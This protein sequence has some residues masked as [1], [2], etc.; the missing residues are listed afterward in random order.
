M[1]G[2]HHSI[3]TV[4]PHARW[5]T[6][7][8]L[9]LGNDLTHGDVEPFEISSHVSRDKQEV[10]GEE[11]KNSWLCMVT[12]A[13]QLDSLM[14]VNVQVLGLRDSKHLM[15][16]QEADIAHFITCLELHNQVFTLPLK[17]CKVSLFASKKNMLAI[18]SH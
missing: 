5:N 18:F 7:F 16:L 17:H 1:T 11:I 14:I 4:L 9:C 3:H 2:Q 6:S 15:I 12:H 13:M 10:I 8:S